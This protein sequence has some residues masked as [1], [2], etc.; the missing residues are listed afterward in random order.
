[1]GS[2]FP[3]RVRKP[4][5]P[6]CQKQKPRPEPGSCSKAGPYPRSIFSTE[7][8]IFSMAIP[9]VSEFMS[10]TYHLQGQPS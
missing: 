2:R 1:M 5:A 10:G 7:M 3:G 8:W 6:R 4:R 9:E